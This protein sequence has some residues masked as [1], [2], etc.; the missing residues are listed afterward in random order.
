MSTQTYT[1]KTRT[2]RRLRE[3]MV[4]TSSGMNPGRHV[5]EE[6]KVHIAELF[7]GSVLKCSGE[8]ATPSDAFKA[9]DLEL[10]K[11]WELVQKGYF[12]RMNALHVARYGEIPF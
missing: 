5:K 10:T 4:Y 1:V 12:A 11:E 9:L 6:H 7:E 2:E 8:G 3:G